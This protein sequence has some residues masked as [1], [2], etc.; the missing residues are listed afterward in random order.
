ML[1]DIEESDAIAFE[2]DARVLRM[3]YA[4]CRARLLS[5]ASSQTEDGEAEEGSRSPVAAASKASPGP[6]VSGR[7]VSEAAVGTRSP[8]AAVASKAPPEPTVSG[9]SGS[10]ACGMHDVSGSAGGSG[11]LPAPAVAAA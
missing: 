2:V 4:Q 1:V 9:G 7:S 6:A 5:H 3:G 11:R 10:P 8:V